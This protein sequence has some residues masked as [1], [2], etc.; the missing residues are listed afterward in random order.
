MADPC[1]VSP[2]PGSLHHVELQVQDLASSTASFDWLFT[3]LGYTAYQKWGGGQSW[4]LGTTYIVIAQAPRDGAHDRRAAGLSHLAFHA[5][6]AKRVDELWASAADHG[7]TQLYAERHPWA[8][9]EDHYAA[10]LENG[11]RFKIE[12][13]A[14]PE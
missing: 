4:I 9:G 13:V 12:L 10:F 7:W 1:K 2:T 5:G 8:G 6:T 3:E 14:E 11:E